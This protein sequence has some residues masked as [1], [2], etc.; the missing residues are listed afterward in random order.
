MPK[1]TTVNSFRGSA[2]TMS[3]TCESC[4]ATITEGD[5][6]R[7]WTNIS[8][9]D[10]AGDKHTRCADS[11]C[12][13]RPSD[14]EGNAKRKPL[15]AAQEN[16]EDRLAEIAEA[17]FDSPQELLDALW[18]ATEI[19]VRGTVESAN[20]VRIGADKLIAHYGRAT[21]GSDQIEAR[22]K[23][24][25]AAGMKLRLEVRFSPWTGE[26]TDNLGAGIPF[27]VDH[28]DWRANCVQ[29]VRRYGEACT[30]LKFS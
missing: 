9:T 8:Q 19:I 7:H 24:V 2:K 21:A 22:A 1:L 25:E 10:R 11:A 14:M 20:V 16:L 28:E 18:N 3:L 29:Q 17:H 5:T 27:D 4:G 12:T 26:L 15:L 13:P 6:Y 30:K 23:R